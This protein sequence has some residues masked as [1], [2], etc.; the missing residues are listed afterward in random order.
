MIWKNLLLTIYAISDIYNLISYGRVKSYIDS[1]HNNTDNSAHLTVLSGDFLSPHKYVGT[2]DSNWI[3]KGL[4]TVPIDLA[5]FGNHEFDLVPTKLNQTLELSNKT[6]FI[7]T[8]IEQIANTEK[9]HLYTDLSNNFSVGFVGICGNDFFTKYPIKFVSDELVNETINRFVSEYKPDYLVGLT[10]MSVEKDIEHAYTF[11]QLDLILGGHIHQLNQTESNRIPILRTGENANHIYQINFYSNKSYSIELV[12]ITN[13]PVE[14]QIQQL[15]LDAEKEFDLDKSIG[16]FYLN[17]TYT[18]DKPRNQIES[19]PKLICQMITRFT[20]SDVTILNSGIFKSH[21]SFTGNFT[22]GMLNDLL[23]F[24]D[25]IVVVQMDWED[26]VKGIEYSKQNHLGKGGFIQT[27]LDFDFDLTFQEKI[28]VSTTVMLLQGVDPNPYFTKY[29][30]SHKK[31]SGT[32][33]HDIFEI[34][35]KNDIV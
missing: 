12:D 18:I 22:R 2:N 20:G 26:L 17:S 6:K 8:N 32:L 16:L 1:K 7:S 3:I 34:Y 4:D 21:G 24:K 25:T 31:D 15:Y 27:D 9:Y 35:Y 13:Y 28:N 14:Q 33:I 19:L 23:P 30:S 5:S 29:F 11:P 10:H